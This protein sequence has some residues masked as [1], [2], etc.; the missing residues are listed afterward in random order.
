MFLAIHNLLP[1]A[2]LYFLIHLRIYQP[3]HHA[4]GP[5]LVDYTRLENC[6]LIVIGIVETLHAVQFLLLDTACNKILDRS[7]YHVII[8]GIVLKE[9]QFIRKA[10]LQHFAEIQ[11]RAVG[12][13]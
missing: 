1:H 6:G 3:Q 10:T 5:R 13:E 8:V 7:I 12:I 4:V 11:E 2:G 9:V